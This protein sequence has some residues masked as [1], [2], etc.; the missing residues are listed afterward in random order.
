[1]VPRCPGASTLA[2]FLYPSLLRPLCHP[3][4]RPALGCDPSAR[5]QPSS[6]A[7]IPTVNNLPESHLNP[8]P[9]DYAAPSFAD[10]ADLSIQAGHGGNG[11]VSFLREAYFPDGPPNGGD[12]GAGGNVYIQAAHGE[13]SLHKLA[14]RRFIRAARGKHGQGSARGGAKG[15]DVV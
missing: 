3:V 14:R 8:R 1:M 10:K 9:D 11:C 4:S 5:R 2:P 15:D 13:T 6:S 7:S 12:G